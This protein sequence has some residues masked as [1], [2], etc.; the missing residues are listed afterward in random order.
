[1]IGDYGALPPEKRN[2]LRVIFENEDL[3]LN[4]P[5]WE[6]FARFSVA[7]FRSETVRAGASTRVQGLVDD[8][9]RKSPQFAAI[10]RD[11]DLGVYGAGT[12]AINHAGVGPVNLEFATFAVDGQ[13][14]LGMIIF[15]PATAEDRAKV[16][17][18]IEA[19]DD[20]KL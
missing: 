6:A 9:S 5:N 13:P 18:I 14:D 10:W 16:R 15:T 4:M 11:Y 12:K 2:I 3:R 1:M 17:R 7:A 8:L 19:K 20:V